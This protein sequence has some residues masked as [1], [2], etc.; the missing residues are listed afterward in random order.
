MM[1]TPIR[2]ERGTPSAGT[3]ETKLEVVVFPEEVAKEG[4]LHMESARR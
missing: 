3:F 1:T 4:A 2:S